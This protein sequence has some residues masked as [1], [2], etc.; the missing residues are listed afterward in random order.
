M[1]QRDPQRSGPENMSPFS[2]KALADSL[3]ILSSHMTKE[4]L[5]KLNT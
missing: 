2:L 1:E 3:I 4:E 5:M